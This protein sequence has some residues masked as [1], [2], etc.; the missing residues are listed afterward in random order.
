MSLD[1]E[2]IL[3]EHAEMIE[4]HEKD[5]TVLQTQTA[6][7]KEL[8]NQRHKEIRDDFHSIREVM[9]HREDII[10][11]RDALKNLQDDMNIV[12]AN[13]AFWKS[14]WFYIFSALATIVTATYFLGGFSSDKQQSTVTA[15]EQQMEIQAL[16]AIADE[17]PKK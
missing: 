5:I 2:K 1:I 7:S 14:Q 11:V 12:K 6:E 13:R 17:L 8:A 3:T 16:Q 15:Q 10:N 9:P 4:K